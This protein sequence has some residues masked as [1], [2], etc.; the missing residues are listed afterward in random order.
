[1]KTPI[2]D[3]EVKAGALSDESKK[4]LSEGK[5]TELDFEVAQILHKINERYN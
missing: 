5:I 4:R 1:M 2:P 3:D